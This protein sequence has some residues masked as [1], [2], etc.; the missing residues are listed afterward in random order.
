VAGS[1]AALIVQARELG[2]VFPGE[3]PYAVERP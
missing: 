2:Y 1:R 3:T